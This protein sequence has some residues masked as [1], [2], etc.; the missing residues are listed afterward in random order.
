MFTAYRGNLEKQVYDLQKST[1]YFDNR[2]VRLEVEYGNYDENNYS[3]DAWHR[4]PIYFSVFGKSYSE[5]NFVQT[6][7]DKG[8]KDNWTNDN[9]SNGFY[10]LNWNTT[11]YLNK[12][13][14]VDGGMEDGPGNTHNWSQYFETSLMGRRGKKWYYLGTINWGFN[15][16]N[17]KLEPLVPK[18]I[19]MPSIFQF[20]HIVRSIFINN[21]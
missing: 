12:F 9:Q 2:K 18:T 8:I 16:N 1:F 14:G 21:K 15:I 7:T 6:A 13:P 19:I 3:D 4:E 11:D 5:Y 20:W 17:H 10:N